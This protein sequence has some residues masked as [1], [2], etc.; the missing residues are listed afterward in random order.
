MLV[1]KGKAMKS[2]VINC[3]ISNNKCICYEYGSYPVCNGSIF[4]NVKKHSLSSLLA[5]IDDSLMYNTD[6]FYDYLIVYT[7]MNE[8]ELSEFVHNLSVREKWFR[9]RQIIVA[10]I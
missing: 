6:D 8:Y 5:E 7:N 3:I 1:L 10:C 2:D 4:G 9:C